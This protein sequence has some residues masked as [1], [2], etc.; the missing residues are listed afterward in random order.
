MLISDFKSMVARKKII[1]NI[2]EALST[3][4]K[5]KKQDSNYEFKENF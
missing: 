2:K 4:D 5:L 3:L 1:G